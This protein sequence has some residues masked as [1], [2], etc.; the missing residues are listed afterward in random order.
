MF[1]MFERDEVMLILFYARDESWQWRRRQCEESDGEG[2]C[3][4]LRGEHRR[5]RRDGLNTCARSGGCCC[6]TR[7]KG[8]CR[9]RRS[10][11]MGHEIAV[12]ARVPMACGG[13]LRRRVF[14][15]LSLRR[16]RAVNAKNSLGASA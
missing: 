9:R 8:V 6:E 10:R 15:G 5:I 4:R 1:A 2:W 7:L 3:A 16:R 13:V 12:A 11:R 14:F